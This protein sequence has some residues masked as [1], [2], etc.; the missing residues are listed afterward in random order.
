LVLWCG[1]AVASTESLPDSSPGS[2]PSG[3][4]RFSA[5]GSGD[6]SGT[7]WNEHQLDKEIARLADRV[8]PA[9]AA[10]TTDDQVVDAFNRV[11][12]EEEGYSYDRVAG[13]PEN[14]LLGSVL[15]RKR[16]NCLGLSMLYLALAERL[17]VPF[18]GVCLPYHCFVRYEGK[19]KVRNVEF[20]SSGEGWPDDRYRMMFR[21]G[22]GRPYLRSLSGTEMSG[23]F[24]KS[25]GAAY[26]KKGREEDALR[27]YEEAVRL[28]PGLPEGHFNA[29]VSLQRMGRIDEAIG[30]YRVAL[31]LDPD[32]APAR[33]NLGILLAIR[34]EFAGAIA[35]G[36]RAVELEPR[37]AAMRRNLA[38][39]YYAS[40]DIEGAIRE[41]RK[42]EELA[43]GN[44]R[45]RTGLV[46]SYL[47]LGRHGEAAQVLENAGA[48]GARIE[49]WLLEA[50]E[51]PSPP[52]HP[53]S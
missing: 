37:S 53:E 29:G 19:A 20:A 23:V 11:L 45:A 18:R 6:L 4:L 49:P 51:L 14:F 26:S 24:L 25:L 52:A 35:E 43:P 22:A 30:K 12:L 39:T 16:G 7:R 50:L 36:K 8:R 9:L 42:A 48:G 33:D 1:P 10:A 17:S 46:R 27:L 31:S 2:F 44:P 28:F 34:G 41:F 5:Q 32:L 40:G 3:Y 13:D 47:A 21:I 38:S 15:S